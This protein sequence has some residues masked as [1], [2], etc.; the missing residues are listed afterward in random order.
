MFR[1]L[2]RTATPLAHRQ[3][4]IATKRTSIVPQSLMRYYSASGLT[5]DDVTT[6]I[7]DVIK[8]YDKSLAA[9]P[10]S[11]ESTYNKDL[12]L[13]SLD[14]VELI[15]AI[16]EEFEIEIPDKVADE[17]KNVGETVDYIVS[18]PDAN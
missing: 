2:L 7:V 3:A 1:Q 13:D 11:L 4:A 12:G 5:K 15:V 18:N 17:L 14:T 8:A 9:K 10:I 6:R 16:E